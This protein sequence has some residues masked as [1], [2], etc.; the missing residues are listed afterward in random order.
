MSQIL[1]VPVVSLTHLVIAHIQFWPLPLDAA[2]RS[3]PGKPLSQLS[4]VD[5]AAE[6]CPGCYHPLLSCKLVAV[7]AYLAQ[8]GPCSIY[9]DSCTWQGT[10]VRPSSAQL[11]L[12][13][14]LL[15]QL[16]MNGLS[17]LA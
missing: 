16:P 5:A 14:I 11:P 12:S 7:I 10:K 1:C 13:Q 9:P 3:V 15:T 4:L 2:A 17:C 8:C 6:P